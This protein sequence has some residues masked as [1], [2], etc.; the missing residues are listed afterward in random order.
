M[1]DIK[2]C[3]GC[4]TLQCF[5]KKVIEEEYPEIKESELCFDCF[6]EMTSEVNALR[7]DVDNGGSNE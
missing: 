3:K 4:Y 2:K 1:M 7:A 5:F 6:D